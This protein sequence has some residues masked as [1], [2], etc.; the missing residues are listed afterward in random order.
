MIGCNS[1]WV[2]VFPKQ[3]ALLASNYLHSIF[4]AWT[5]TRSPQSP[6]V[7]KCI[8]ALRLQ[9]YARYYLENDLKIEFKLVT[10]SVPSMISNKYGSSSNERSL[11]SF[12]DLKLISSNNVFRLFF[13]PNI[14]ITHPP[15]RSESFKST[16]PWPDDN[17]APPCN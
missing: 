8:F 6:Q 3:V 16:N 10:S 15:R 11:Y 9:K 13:Q 12:L 4:L 2:G 1:R 14:V 7:A 5:N 17:K